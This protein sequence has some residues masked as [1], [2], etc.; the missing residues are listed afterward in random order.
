MTPD[1]VARLEDTLNRILK[2]VRDINSRV[3]K[4]ELWK[5]K[6]E[7]A[8]MALKGVWWVGSAAIGTVLGISA[9]AITLIV[10]G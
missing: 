3:Q 1:D 2:E 4:V 10:G 7:G 6:M 8:G 5:A 9:A